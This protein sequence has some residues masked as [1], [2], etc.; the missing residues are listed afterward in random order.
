MAY[1]AVY[2]IETGVIQNVVE[3][4]DF[5]ESTIHL[6]HGQD[7]LKIEGQIVQANYLVINQKLVES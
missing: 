5:L 1:F 6:D 4:P 2:Q 3:C 7:V